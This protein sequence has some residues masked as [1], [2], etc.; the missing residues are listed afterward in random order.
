MA[1]VIVTN[2]SSKLSARYKALLRKIPEASDRAMRQL[3]ESEGLPLY[4]ATTRTWQRK[5]RF[6]VVKKSRGWSIVT[7]DERYKFVDFGTRPHIIRARNAPFLVFRWPYRSATKVNWLSSRQIQRGDNW[8]KRKQVRHPGIQARNFTDIISKRLQ[9]RAKSA[10]QSEI[11]KLI[12][13]EGFGL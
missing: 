5:P 6:A 10:V 8:S 13:A 4:Q 3:L 9:K 2:N 7:N 12:D 11:K 1:K